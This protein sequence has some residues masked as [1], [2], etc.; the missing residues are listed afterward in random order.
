MELSILTPQ[1]KLVDAIHVD[2]IFAPASVGTLDILPGHANLLSELETGILK[3][4]QGNI[5]K[6]AAVSFGW[7]EITNQKITV[8]AD[9]AELAE[10]LDLKRAR[11]ALINAKKKVEEGGLDQMSFRK[12]ELK[13]KRA[14][15][16]ENIAAGN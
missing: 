7:L 10:E 9:V 6:Q 5:W 2:E 15:T 8:L 13:M 12:W 16:R 1:K 14:M 3:W 4:R 11:T